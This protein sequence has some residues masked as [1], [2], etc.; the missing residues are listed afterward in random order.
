MALPGHSNLNTRSGAYTCS[1]ADA[2]PI[3]QTG[4]WEDNGDD[5]ALRTLA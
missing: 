4:A 2:A 3:V 5:T 1:Y